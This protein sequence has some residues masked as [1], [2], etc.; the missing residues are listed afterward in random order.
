MNT[1]LLEV[2]NL[3]KYFASQKAWPWQTTARPLKAVDDVSFSMEKGETVAIVGE[4]GC[5]KTTLGR[6]CIR[7]YPV[8]DGSLRWKGQEIAHLH[9]EGLRPLR[10]EMQIIFQDPFLSLNPKWKVKDL[11]EEGL[12]NFF[13]DLGTIGREERIKTLLAE[14]G[15]DPS[16]LHRHAHEFSG[17]QRQRIALA[18]ALAVEP[19]LIVCDEVV[20][21]LDVS[22]KSQILNLLRDLKERKGIAYLFIVHDMEL[23]AMIADKILVMYLG[24]IVEVLPQG[25][26]DQAQHPYTQGL[27]QSIPQLG[28]P[29]ELE[30]PWRHAEPPSPAM[31]PSGCRF[32]T[33]C[34]QVMPECKTQKPGQRQH[35][36][37]GTQHLVSCHKY[38]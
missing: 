3:K 23:A 8:T 25:G 35:E 4:S 19:E 18:R 28:K 33:R 13:P 24:R 10:K 16:M 21:A 22:I 29:L 15:L 9:K 17:G 5:G 27:L 11:I 32:H 1:P 34:P 20:S 38:K 37:S 12:R 26:L 36:K 14:V 31:L 2:K 30:S 7:L 6:T